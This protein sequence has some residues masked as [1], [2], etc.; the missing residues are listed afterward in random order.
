MRTPMTDKRWFWHNVKWYST[1]AING[2]TL[3]IC[4]YVW[5]TWAGVL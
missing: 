1:L 4:S 5:L 2:V 3:A